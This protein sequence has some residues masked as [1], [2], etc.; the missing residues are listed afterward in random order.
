M[1]L[2]PV[3]LATAGMAALLNL[4]LGMRIGR[5]RMRERISIGDGGNE[6]LAARMRAQLNFAEYTPIVLILMAGIELTRGTSVLLGL[7]GI[8][9]LLGRVA[10]AIGMDGAMKARQ[11]GAI[12][13]LAVTGVLGIYAIAVSHMP[14][15]HPLER[16]APPDIGAG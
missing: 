13:T 15:P 2:L 14:P 7:V 11:A 1:T 9:Y 12:I 6:L 10:H 5:I 16:L 3:T 8:V 4:W